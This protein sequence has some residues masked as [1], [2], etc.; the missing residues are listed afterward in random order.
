MA[1]PQVFVNV[2]AAN[3]S[4]Q[5]AFV[6][7]GS[8][9][10]DDAITPVIQITL[11]AGATTLGPFGATLGADHTFSTTL[12]PIPVGVWNL[13]VSLKD[14]TAAVSRNIT[15]VAPGNG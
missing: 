5:Q 1:V 14:T 13:E 12:N 7:S 11:T 15:V 8:Y 9:V 3:A 6:V 2:P 10:P 4:V